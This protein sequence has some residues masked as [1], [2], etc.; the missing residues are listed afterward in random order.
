[1]RCGTAGALMRSGVLHAVP[2]T[3]L[4]ELEGDLTNLHST[5]I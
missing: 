3:A 4:V 5:K 2:R 1:M